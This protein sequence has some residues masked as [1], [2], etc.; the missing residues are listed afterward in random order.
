MISTFPQ[1]EPDHPAIRPELKQKLEAI[2]KRQ[3]TTLSVLLNEIIA[4]WLGIE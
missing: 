3:N 4:S 1:Y 2:A